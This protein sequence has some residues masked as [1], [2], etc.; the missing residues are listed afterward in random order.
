VSDTGIGIAS[1]D[2]PKVLA[3]F[4]QVESKIRRKHEGTGLGLPLAKQLVDLHGGLLTID[5]KLDAGTTVTILLPA[6][7]MIAARSRATAASAVA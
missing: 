5:S 3:P 1:D 6:S 2:I 7:R 4:G